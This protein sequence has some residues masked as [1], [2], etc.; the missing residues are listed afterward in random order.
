MFGNFQQSHLRIEIEA[1][2]AAIG[3]SLL[4]LE[5]LRQW[6]PQRLPT[7][8]PD[9]LTEGTQF[10]S[11]LGPVPIEQVVTLA[12]DHRLRL[13]LS[14]GIDGYHEWTWGEGW[15]QS[16]IEGIS[17]IPLNLG[18]TLSLL[19]LRTFLELQQLQDAA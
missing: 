2:A 5:Q 14:Q 8:V 16:C 18:Q 1:S 17:L 11:F 4:H 9:R 10:T 6:T 7:G 13:L 15:V 3:K 12:N 19:R